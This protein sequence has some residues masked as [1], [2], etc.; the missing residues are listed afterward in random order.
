MEVEKMEREN[1][2]GFG[3]ERVYR[4]VVCMDGGEKM[5]E[6]MDFV[7]EIAKE[8]KL[9]PIDVRVRGDPDYMEE[10]E[11]GIMDILDF[12]W[13]Y[14]QTT[15]GFLLQIEKE[16]PEFITIECGYRPD[17]SRYH[18]SR[19]ETLVTDGQ[20]IFVSRLV[21]S[22]GNTHHD[23]YYK[24]K[25]INATFVLVI[26]Y[27]ENNFNGENRYLHVFYYGDKNSKLVN[28]LRRLN[29]LLTP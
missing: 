23:E 7:G 24:Y 10:Y 8:E 3:V 17:I 13:T 9:E 4:N 14:G 6:K 2:E 16:I 22:D 15:G 5:E 29:D 21:D 20:T 19:S 25:V 12:I 28:V 27:E 11:T 1:V 26:G 18:Y